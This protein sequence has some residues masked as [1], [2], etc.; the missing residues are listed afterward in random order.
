MSPAADGPLGL[1]CAC[2]AAGY[3]R[4]GLV[5]GPAAALAEPA[6]DLVRLARLAGRH[7]VTPMLAACVADPVLAPRLPDDFRRYVALVHGGNARR[8]RALRRQLAEAVGC[9][10]GTGI[11]PVLLK[12][13]ARLADGLYPD[14]GWRLMRDLDLLVPRDR[15]AEAAACLRSAGYRFLE[16]GAGWS[17]RH[18]HLP[19]LARD[20][21]PAVIEV[22][23]EP[24]PA[25]RAACPAEA[26]I[27]RSRAADLDGALAR[28][29]D[30]VDQ[31]ALL[32]VHDRL[33]RC[34]AEGGLSF[35]LRSIFEG[36]LL[37]RD[38]RHADAVLARCAAAG[39]GPWAEARLALAAR[40][41]PDLVPAPPVGLAARLRAGALVAAGRWDEGGALRRLSC[42]ATRRVRE[43]VSSP[44]TRARVAGGLLSPAYLRH[45]ASRLQELRRGG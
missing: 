18:H 24:L 13:A 37:C 3:R 33:D 39:L 6:T 41:F 21:A 14:P 2:L 12:G 22:H 15:A 19:Q 7:L 38:R 11:E 17:G 20:G 30:A 25:R 5:D 1:L 43:L 26:V 29:P 40:L 34:L 4:Q 44:A 45:C 35:L 42:F 31:L 23:A 9:L 8:N 10:N 27:A 28:V 16:G 36:A 32:L